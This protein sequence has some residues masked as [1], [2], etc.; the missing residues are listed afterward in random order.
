MRHRGIITDHP[1]LTILPRNEDYAADIFKIE[2]AIL[3][4]RAKESKN[5][6]Y[7]SEKVKYW[8]RLGEA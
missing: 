7:M 5:E 6:L 1:D 4:L 3:G 2:S 8:I